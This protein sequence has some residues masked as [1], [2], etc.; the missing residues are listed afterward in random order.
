M[1]RVVRTCAGLFDT[2]RAAQLAGLA[3]TNYGAVVES[4]LSVSLS[5]DYTHYN[6]GVRPIG[7]LPPARPR[8][9]HVAG[10]TLGLTCVCGACGVH[11][12][13]EPL[14]YA[15]EDVVYLPQVGHML[16]ARV[17]ELGVEEELAAV[18][19][20]LM[21][22]PSHPRRYLTTA[23]ATTPITPSSPPPPSWSAPC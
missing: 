3:H 10:S 13:L 1:C 15:L 5:K 18:N 19:R 2:Q 4:L 6:W 22:M 11:A 21:A 8:R 23:T 14:R 12:E 9:N 17:Q 20:M 16:R 7:I